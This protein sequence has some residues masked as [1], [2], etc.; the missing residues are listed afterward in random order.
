MRYSEVVGDVRDPRFE[1]CGTFST[2]F[3]ERAEN[4]G[5]L[6]DGE[7]RIQTWTVGPVFHSRVVG[8]GSRPLWKFF[9]NRLT[10]LTVHHPKVFAFH[11]WS[12]VSGYDAKARDENLELAKTAYGPLVAEIHILFG[13]SVIAM[14]VSVAGIVLTGLRGYSDPAAFL[15]RDDRV[16]AEPSKQE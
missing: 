7:N 5:E 16:R 9:E 8:Y 15:N 3:D 14:A 12:R 2:L 13:S 1:S 6:A 10:L 11:D 4:F